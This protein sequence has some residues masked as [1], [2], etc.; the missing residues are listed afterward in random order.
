MHDPH[1]PPSL[2]DRTPEPRCDPRSLLRLEVGLLRERE[3]RRV[4]DTAVH[5]GVLGGPRTGFVARAADLP[6]LDAGL[7]AD[8][9]A[10]LLQSTPPSWRCGWVTRAGAPSVHDL[11][12]QWL[13][14]VR[15]AFRAHGRQLEGCYVLTRTG[16]RDA[17]TGESRT[18]VRLRL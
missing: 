6:V 2:P 18:W 3:S 10:T 15:T 9:L 4:F 13:A 16:W 1:E 12:G 17:D 5:V 7:R 8:V 14:A 11:D